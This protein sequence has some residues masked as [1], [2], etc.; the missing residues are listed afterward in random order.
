MSTQHSVTH[1]T[2]VIERTYPASPARVF[3]AFADPAIKSRWFG[4]DEMPKTHHE[5]DFRVGGRE[6]NRGGPP[7][8]PTYTYDAR[9]EDI[10]QDERIVTSYVMYMGEARISVSVASVELVAEGTGTRLVYTDQGAYLDG[11]D[12]PA[13]R[14]EGTRELLDALGA[15]LARSQS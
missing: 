4:N 7:D 1:A 3:N 12:N 14:E 13:Q 8:G 5:M 10:L 2:F 11:Y 6:I 9:Y 15:E